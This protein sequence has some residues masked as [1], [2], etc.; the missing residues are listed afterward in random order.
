MNLRLRKSSPR[1][2]IGLDI[3][4]A[5]LAAAQVS[6]GAVTRAASMELPAGLMSEGEV[7]DSAGLGEALKSFFERNSL[8]RAARLG[9]ANQQIAVRQVQL[10]VIEDKRER[11]AAVRFQAAETIPMPL[12][13]VV[14]DYDAVGETTTPEGATQMSMIVVAARESMVTP[15]VEAVREAGI[16][17]LGIDLNAFALVRLLAAASVD[18]GDVVDSTH[19]AR[20]YCHLAGTTN[21]AV[22]AGNSCLF[23][24]ALSTT[25]DSH[26]D[27]TASALAEEIRLSIDFYMTQP[28]SRPATEIVL[29]GPG[30]NAP[31]LSEELTSLLSTPVHV[32]DPLGRL[33]D[34]LPAQEDPYVYSVAAGLAMGESA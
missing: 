12:E 26:G 3:D 4:G 1:G 16:R 31:A 28:E 13:E 22:A 2:S 32:A 18:N 5:F 9:V 30:A 21:L 17:P 10:P 20:V 27:D 25:W 24:R 14:L 15:L 23:T 7:V 19:D 29:S 6:G 8:P 11:E 34:A 33:V